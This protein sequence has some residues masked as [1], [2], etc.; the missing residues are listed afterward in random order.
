MWVYNLPGVEIRTA[1]QVYMVNSSYF[2]IYNDFIGIYF[3]S[4]KLLF[5]IFFINFGFIERNAKFYYFDSGYGPKRE[6]ICFSRRSHN[7]ISGIHN[8]FLVRMT[9]YF[10]LSLCIYLLIDY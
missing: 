6:T 10:M 2:F 5:L 1:N 9:P 3:F 8:L 4:H 7:S